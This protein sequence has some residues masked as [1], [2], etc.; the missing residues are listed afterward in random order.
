M[1][2]FMHHFLS[3]LVL[4]ALLFSCAKEQKSF[5]F[6]QL[7]DTQLGFGGYRHDSLSFHQAVRMINQLHPDFVVICGDLVND[8][9]AK[10][11]TDFLAIAEGFEMPYYPA[12]GN[13]DVGNEPN[14]STLA[15]YRRT[16]GPDFY[17]QDHKGC[18]VIVTNSQLWKSPVAGA[19]EKHHEWFKAALA[20]HFEDGPLFVVG[21][22]PLFLESPEEEEAYFNL[23]KPI[24]GELIGLLEQYEVSAYLAGH[25][26]RRVINR[27]NGVNYVGGETISK[28]F[29]ETPLG[30]RLWTV[31]EDTAYH[32]FVA[33]DSLEEITN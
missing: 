2:T 3:V 13:H 6:V 7:C 22:Y 18:R 29:D 25:T 1:I 20:G 21:H 31:A 15:V 9:N 26:H 32:Q 17:H 14:D 5:S 27:H 23:P 28:N 10:S 4:S 19:S 11:F 33:L 16:I 8:R 24:R 30:F 12:P